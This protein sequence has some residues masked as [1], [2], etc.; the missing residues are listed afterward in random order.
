F[1]N[2]QGLRRYKDKYDPVWEP[3]YVASPGGLSFPLAL[4]NVASLVSRG[5]TG[6]VHR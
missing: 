2:F 3:R 6:V 4:T 1:Y 5:I